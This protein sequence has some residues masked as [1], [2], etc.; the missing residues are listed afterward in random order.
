MLRSVKEVCWARLLN[1][2]YEALNKAV[3]KALWLQSPFSWMGNDPQSPHS[4]TSA[5]SRDADTRPPA[6]PMEL[7]CSWRAGMLS[8]HGHA[9]PAL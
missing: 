1:D 4:N 6:A 3:M 2:D 7:R 8:Y 5:T 9:P